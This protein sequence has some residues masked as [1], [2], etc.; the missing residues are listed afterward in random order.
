M[1]LL[2]ILLTL[3]PTLTIYSQDKNSIIEFGHTTLTIQSLAPFD[4]EDLKH[5]GSDKI[6][7][8]ADLGEILESATIII[9]TEKY[10]DIE[11]YQAL[12]TSITIMDEGPHCDLTNWKHFTTDWRNLKK[13]ETNT[14]QVTPYE[15]GE[16]RKFPKVTMQEVMEAARQECGENWAKHI[17]NSKS[18]Y[19]D[20]CDVGVSRYFLKIIGTEK[21][22]GE[23]IKK[24]IVVFIPM[25]C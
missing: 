5:I 8:T 22:T 13:L 6:E 7:F 18:I 23:K 11:I 19:E 24:E 2:T 12:E 9:R 21:T 3:I 1:R 17:E 15:N 10:K 16:S 14:Y 4:S 20:H 25:G